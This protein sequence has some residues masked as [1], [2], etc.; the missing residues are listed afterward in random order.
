MYVSLVTRFTDHMRELGPMGEK[1]GMAREELMHKLGVACE[2]SRGLKLRTR[3][4]RLAHILRKEG[5]YSPEVIDLKI[6]EKIED[7]IVSEMRKI[8]A[9]SPH[10][11]EIIP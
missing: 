8:E 2:A 10:P 9:A 4:G 5:G 1:E 3:L 11:Q 6:A 7:I